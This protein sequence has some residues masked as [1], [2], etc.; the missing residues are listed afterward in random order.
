MPLFNT[1][2]LQKVLFSIPIT[3]KFKIQS[4]KL[5]N[6]DQIFEYSKLHSPLEL[7]PKPLLKPDGLALHFE[8]AL[9]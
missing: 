1:N 5:S 6:S 8:L 9:L 4:C 7:F 3:L 2:P